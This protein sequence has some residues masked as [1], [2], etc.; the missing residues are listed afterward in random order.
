MISFNKL[1][2]KQKSHRDKCIEKAKYISNTVKLD[3]L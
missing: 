1:N 3:E 2:D